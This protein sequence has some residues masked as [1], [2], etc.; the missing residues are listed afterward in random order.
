MAANFAKLAEL[1]RRERLKI[2]QCRASITPYN[3][4][5]AT[6][7]AAMMRKAIDALRRHLADAMTWAKRTVETVCS[8]VG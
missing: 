1:L 4:R 3:A 7:F 6:Q 2:S 5:W 8:E